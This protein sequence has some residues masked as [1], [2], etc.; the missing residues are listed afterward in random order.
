MW[1]QR[2]DAGGLTFVGG[3]VALIRNDRPEEA[4]VIEAPVLVRRPS[5]YV[6]FYSGGS[7]RRVVR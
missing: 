4:G 3:R 5:Q 1:L 6:M 7:L 2:V